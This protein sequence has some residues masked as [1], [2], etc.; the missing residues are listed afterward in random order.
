[1]F[2]PQEILLALAWVRKHAE[3][4]E[5]HAELLVSKLLANRIEESQ[6]K[7]DFW[8]SQCVSAERAMDRLDK[9]K[10]K[11]EKTDGNS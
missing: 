6:S 5:D 4:G 7:M 2:N 8:E 9:M 11:R 10:T 3:P 1:M